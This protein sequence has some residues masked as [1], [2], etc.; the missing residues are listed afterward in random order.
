MPLVLVAV[1]QP[2]VKHRRRAVPKL[3]REGRREEVRVRQGLVVDDRHRPPARSRHGEVVGV[4]QVNALHPPQDAV[5][6]VAPHHDVVARIVRPLHAGEVAR[7][8]GR[9]ST[10]ARIAVG[11]FHRERSSAHCGHFIHHLALLRGRHLRC[12]HGHH[13]LLQ[14]HAQHHGTAACHDNPVQHAR[15]V[16]NERHLQGVSPQRHISQLKPPVEVGGC[17]VLRRSQHLNRRTQQR[18]ARFGIDHRARH[19][20]GL[21]P[22][23][24][25]KHHQPHPHRP[26]QLA[27]P[28]PQN[29]EFHAPKVGNPSIMP[30]HIKRL[31]MRKIRAGTRS[32]DL[33]QRRPLDKAFSCENRASR[34]RLERHN[35]E[36]CDHRKCEQGGLDGM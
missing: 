15:L 26:P 27:A 14:L 18:V 32:C 11:L 35:Q 36:G 23:A 4:G 28:F 9:I 19:R 7:H 17:H 3:S 33:G 8:S 10:R 25:G 6:A 30:P 12:L 1:A 24:H 22:T 2:Q 16:P 29:I 20:G 21:G 5:G 31:S 13:A 34:P